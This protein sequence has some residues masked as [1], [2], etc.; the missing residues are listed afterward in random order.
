MDID[1]DFEGVSEVSLE[2]G[3]VHFRESGKEHTFSVPAND[4]L[5]MG[6]TEAAVG[7]Q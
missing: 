3:H 6:V 4:S 1:P 7:C 5:L 2:A